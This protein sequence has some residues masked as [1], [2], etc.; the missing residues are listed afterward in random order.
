MAETGSPTSVMMDAIAEL[1]HTELHPIKQELNSIK[2][3]VN[4]IKQTMHTE[5]NSIKRSVNRLEQSRGRRRPGQKH[6]LCLASILASV[7]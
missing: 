5:L 6:A 7:C 2:Q 3:E 1:L 4:Y